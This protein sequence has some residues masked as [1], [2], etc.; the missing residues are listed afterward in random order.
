M[1][2]C[3]YAP[4]SLGL[5]LGLGRLWPYLQALDKTGGVYQ[6]QTL[7]LIGPIRKLRIN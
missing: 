5:G 3:E 1:K 2:F 6:G 4:R 7:S